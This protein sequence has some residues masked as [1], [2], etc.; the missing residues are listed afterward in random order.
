MKY[1]CNTGADERKSDPDGGPSHLEVADKIRWFPGRA[2]QLCR[3]LLE[4]NQLNTWH[5]QA[6]TVAVLIPSQRN[7]LLKDR[8]E[9]N[10]PSLLFQA[11]D[12]H[13]QHL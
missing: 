13:F 7:L 11:V 4:K 10:V 8:L 2:K 12:N 5:E 9:Q 6:P 1:D 3:Q